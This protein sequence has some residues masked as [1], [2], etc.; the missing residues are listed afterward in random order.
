MKIVLVYAFPP[1]SPQIQ[2]PHSITHYLYNYLK[3]RCDLVYYMW[4][5]KRIPPAD[6][7][8]IFIGHPHYDQSTIVQRVFRE[9]I[10]FK[11]KCTI[12]PF[13]HALPQY[14]SPFH[15]L[16]RKADK[17][18]G[19]CG[20]YW[21]DTMQNTEFAFWKPKMTRLD[22]AVDGK[23]YPYLKNNFNPPGKR[24]LV[25]IGSDM[26]MK[27]VG[28]LTEIMKRMSHVELHWYGGNGEHPL[29]KLS[30]V[31]TTGWVTLD[32]DLATK[33][34]KECD[35][36]I[37]VSTSDANPTTLLEARA[38]GLI[39]ACSKESGYYN[40]RFFTELSST[41]ISKTINQLQSLLNM[42]SSELM[43]RAK[44]SRKEIETKYNWDRFCNTVWKELQLI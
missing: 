24:R 43:T 4:D 21:Y 38:W 2:S 44:D 12:H 30:N 35:I 13:H 20:P 10:P 36:M 3:K 22:M 40:D 29:A 15:D 39:T 26:P 25:Y 7:E 32:R 33:I 5:E 19:I 23:V 34:C 14:N 18:F 16:A 8:A 41:D 27:N 37:N 17:I 1:N 6:P 28:F 11:M 42:P 9:N 31:K